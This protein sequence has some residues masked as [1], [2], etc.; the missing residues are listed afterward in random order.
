MGGRF[1]L[2]KIKGRRVPNDGRQV[3]KI[4]KHNILN[5]NFQSTEKF[6]CFNLYLKETFNFFMNRI[7]PTCLAYL[8]RFILSENIC[9]HH[10]GINWETNLGYVT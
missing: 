8:K 4:F 2:N 5:L 3:T 7:L 9:L 10:C 6:D 1:Q